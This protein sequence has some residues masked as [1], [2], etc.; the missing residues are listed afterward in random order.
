MTKKLLYFAPLAALVA[1]PAASAAKDP[2]KASPLVGAL[3]ACRSITDGAER[4]ACY[5]KASE[6]LVTAT[7]AGDVT[8]VSRAETRAARRSL[9]GFSMPKLP[10]FAGDDS[11]GDA[12]EAIETVIK[13]VSGIGYGKFR[14]VIAEG[15]AVW[16]TTETFG[17]MREPRA[18]QKIRIKRGSLGSYMLNIDGQ[19]GVKGKRVG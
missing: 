7:K 14:I 18:G 1:L 5:D 4:L 17:T 12:P 8:V 9:F 10:F 15:D 16:E 13:Q 3:E 6:A 19:R 2:P 11:A